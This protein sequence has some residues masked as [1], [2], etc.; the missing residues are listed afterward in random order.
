MQRGK[1]S[2]ICEVCRMDY[3][4]NFKLVKCVV[5]E[6]VI[7]SPDSMPESW[8]TLTHRLGRVSGIEMPSYFLNKIFI[9]FFAVF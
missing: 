3:L 7:E 9:H 4:H 1:L 5:N 2:Q 6:Y 8:A